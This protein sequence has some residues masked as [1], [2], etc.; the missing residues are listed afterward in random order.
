MIKD[1]DISVVT[2]ADSK[3]SLPIRVYYE[4]ADQTGEEVQAEVEEILDNSKPVLA[5]W[6]IV[7][8]E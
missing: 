2:T 1:T 4:A 7:K 3:I 8:V 6:S 5:V